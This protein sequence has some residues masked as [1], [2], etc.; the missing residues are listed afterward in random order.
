[1]R[2]APLE[3]I[4]AEGFELSEEEKEALQQ[5]D[6]SVSDEELNRQASFGG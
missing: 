4:A 5:L 1:M 6:L 3:T 2:A